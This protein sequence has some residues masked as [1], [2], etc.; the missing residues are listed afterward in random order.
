MTYIDNT[1]D[2]L[3]GVGTLS[4]SY[5]LLMTYFRPS[6]LQLHL[7]HHTHK[8]S[9]SHT[10]SWHCIPVSIPEDQP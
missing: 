5:G 2:I 10:G 4:H 7:T 3:M 8:T 1:Y 9:A 6:L